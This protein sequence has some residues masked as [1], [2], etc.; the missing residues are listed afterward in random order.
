MTLPPPRS[1]SLPRADFFVTGTDTGVGKSLVAAAL[2]RHLGQTGRRAVG[3]K[4]VAAGTSWV[5]GRWCND[6]V[7]ALSAASNVQ[8]PAPWV[9]PYLLR[10][11]MAPHIAAEN[12]GIPLRLDHLQACFAQLQSVSDSVV[13]EGAGGFSVPI[14]A[15][16]TLADL[17]QVLAVPVVL[18]VGIR[19]GCLN[20]ALLTAQAIRQAGLPLVGWV[21]NHIDPEM[22][23]PVENVNSLAQRLG[24]PCWAQI[25]WQMQSPRISFADGLETIPSIIVPSY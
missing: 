12:E 5:D 3:M 1:R 11:A 8:A 13:V 22:S 7:E 23:A 20:H 25:P 18:V 21:A 4:P 15:T 9:C 2:L 14:N 17:A 16:E 6:D 24:A 10:D 19:L